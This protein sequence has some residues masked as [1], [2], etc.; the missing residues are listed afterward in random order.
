MQSVAFNQ[1]IRLAQQ[2]TEEVI[3]ETTDSDN[4]SVVILVTGFVVVF[5]VLLLLIGIIKVYSA[6]VCA[7]QNKTKKVKTAPEAVT[8]P[9]VSSVSPVD[10]LID[11]GLDLQT[12]AV[13]TAAVEAYYSKGKKVR[14]TGI[15]S[16]QSL[17]SEWATAGL[18]E[19]IPGMR[20]EGLL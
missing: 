16:S 11:D 13:I 15:R 4:Q 8:E 7:A 3:K 18:F 1:A 5:L 20:S 12:V 9:P 2:A 17:R 10:D 6:L 19:N 14:I